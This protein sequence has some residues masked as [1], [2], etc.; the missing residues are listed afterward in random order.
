M[1]GQKVESEDPQIM[2]YNALLNYSTEAILT[3][4]ILPSV[5]LITLWTGGKTG[6]AKAPSL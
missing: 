1:G 6:H 2:N 5:L 4:D 3:K